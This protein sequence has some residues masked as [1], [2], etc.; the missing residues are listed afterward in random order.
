MRKTVCEREKESARVQ[1]RQCEREREREREK[2]RE[3]ERETVLF[4]NALNTFLFTDISHRTSDIETKP[5]AATS[6]AIPQS[7]THLF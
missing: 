7:T 5:T 2:E 1:E 6:V 3:R 4:K